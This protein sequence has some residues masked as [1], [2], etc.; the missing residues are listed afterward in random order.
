MGDYRLIISRAGSAA[1]GDDLYMVGERTEREDVFDEVGGVVDEGGD[2]VERIE[3]QEPAKEEE[4]GQV[5]QLGE[6]K[7]GAGG[8]AHLEV[9]AK[10]CAE[11]SDAVVAVNASDSDLGWEETMMGGADEC[12]VEI[13]RVEPEQEAAMWHAEDECATGLEQAHNLAYGSA[14]VGEV[15]KY[16]EEEESVERCAGQWDVRGICQQIGSVGA[17]ASCLGDVGWRV[18]NADGIIAALFEHARG[19][20]EGAAKIEHT[21]LVERQSRERSCPACHA[22]FPMSIWPVVWID[23]LSVLCAIQCVAL[24][25]HYLYVGTMLLCNV[26]VVLAVSPGT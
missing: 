26:Y 19:K 8:A 3:R 23:D 1:C 16:V 7:A 24:H 6:A 12:G 22:P 18:V 13:E 15:F 17:G 20:T 9:V 11:L 10:E 21:S 2:S 14:F 25:W 4:Q 5:D